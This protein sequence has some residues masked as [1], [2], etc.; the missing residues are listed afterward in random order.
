[1]LPLGGVPSTLKV[2]DVLV[3]ERLHT[4][5]AHF[6]SAEGKDS[7]LGIEMHRYRH[8]FFSLL[9]FNPLPN[10]KPS[11]FGKYNV[12]SHFTLHT[13]SM[14]FASVNEILLDMLKFLP[15]NW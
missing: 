13:Q 3:W 4:N 7:T 14:V 2:V 6:F 15:L 8:F 5:A 11:E 9:L 12:S 1:M 10:P